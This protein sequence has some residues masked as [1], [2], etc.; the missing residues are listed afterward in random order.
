MLKLA[1]EGRRNMPTKNKM[2]SANVR[3]AILSTGP[4]LFAV[5]L[6][7][8][9]REAFNLPTTEFDRWFSSFRDSPYSILIVIISFI[10]GSFF[11]VPQWALFVAVITVFGPIYGSILSW[12]SSLVSGSFNFFFGR[13]FGLSWLNRAV[14]AGGRAARFVEALRQNGFLA[15]FAVRFVPTGPFILVN[16]VAGA[17][18]LGYSAFIAGTA[19][20]I[21]PKILVVAFLAQGVLGE[22]DRLGASLFFLGL[23]C[24]VIGS[25]WLLKRKF[26]ATQVQSPED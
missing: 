16:A 19:L 3:A 18:G 9:L 11:A 26:S 15:S 22:D 17:S 6:V 12:G 13:L 14:N 5:I 2:K 24:L 8:V 25:S 7:L 20:G 4:L 10:A 23:A 21:I 1:A